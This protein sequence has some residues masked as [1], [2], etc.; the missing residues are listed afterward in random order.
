MFKN[1]PICECMFKDGD[2]IV[3]IMVAE[4]HKIDSEVN[5]A[6]S[7]PERCIEI[8]HSDCYDWDEHDED[9]DNNE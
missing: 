6:I 5:V 9:G 3:A 7:H 4:F 8:V 2:K 1:C